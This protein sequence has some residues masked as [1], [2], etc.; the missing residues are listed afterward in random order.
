MARHFLVLPKR[1]FQFMP[2]EQLHFRA[3]G[4]CPDI[5]ACRVFRLTPGISIG[6]HA[7]LFAFTA[8]VPSHL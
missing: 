2:E 3:R 5:V 6:P 7:L 4:I 1:R 8:S